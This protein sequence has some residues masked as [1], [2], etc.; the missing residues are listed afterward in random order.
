[1]EEKNKKASRQWGVCVEHLKRCKTS[2]LCFAFQLDFQQGMRGHMRLHRTKLLI[3]GYCIT[4]DAC[5]VPA[6]PC[7]FSRQWPAAKPRT[8]MSISKQ[9]CFPSLPVRFSQSNWAAS[10]PV[11]PLSKDKERHP[12][13]RCRVL[14]LICTG[15]QKAACSDASYT[16]D[17]FAMSCMHGRV[18]QKFIF[19]LHGML[20]FGYADE[21]SWE[22]CF[23]EM[24]S[25]LLC[26]VFCI[27]A[28]PMS[29]VRRCAVRRCAPVFA[30]WPRGWIELEDIQHLE[31]W[32]LTHTLYI[33]SSEIFCVGRIGLKPFLKSF[34][35]FQRLSNCF[36]RVLRW[37]M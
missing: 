10:E 13:T 26:M 7:Q 8:G 20:H 36:A 31:N 15:P 19:I 32:S 4:R 34:E 3:L 1:M 2:N 29:L 6:T 22:I 9:F 23:L 14:G 27:L 18:Y 12:S 37:T 21:H 30:L 33:P 16:Q 5:D 28:S 35:M 11:G 24:R 25:S 17:F